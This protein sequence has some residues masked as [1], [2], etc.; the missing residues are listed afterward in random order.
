MLVSWCTR[1][2]AVSV[3]AEFEAHAINGKLNNPIHRVSE[4]TFVVRRAPNSEALI[5]LLHMKL[6]RK[7]KFQCSCREF[8]QM[9][10]LCGATTAP[11]VSHRCIHVCIC[12]WAVFSS[13]K[14]EELSLCLFDDPC[15]VMVCCFCMHYYYR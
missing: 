1:G 8:R 13:D 9:S 7:R 6:D 14:L 10:S 3:V 15:M 2:H 12:L 4:H 5:G 11:K